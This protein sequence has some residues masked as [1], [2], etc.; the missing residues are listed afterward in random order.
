MNT[1]HPEILQIRYDVAAAVLVAGM[2][3]GLAVRF[4]A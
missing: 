1:M 3:V 2:V 4:F